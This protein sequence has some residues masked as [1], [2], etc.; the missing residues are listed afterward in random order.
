M[1]K[2]L[3]TQNQM[4][5]INDPAVVAELTDLYLKYEKALGVND[6]ETLDYL[7]WDSPETLRFGITEN[8]YGSEEIKAFRQSR[9]PVNIQE[10]F[11]LKVVTFEA[12]MAAVTVEFRQVVDG[13]PRLGRQSQ[14]WRKFPEGWKIVS[15][16][17]S[18]M[19]T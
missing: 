17:V 13:I 15:A 18:Y 12:D 14:M 1:L 5:R 11:N 9:S 19:L 7:F 8:L 3:T 4:T 10:M 2:V 16:H 6:V